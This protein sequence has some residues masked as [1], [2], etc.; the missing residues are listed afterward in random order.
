MQDF[1]KLNQLNL[2][3]SE[4][5]ASSQISL[6]PHYALLQNDLK[7]LSVRYNMLCAM[8]ESKPYYFKTD[9]DGRFVLKDE[10]I[11]PLVFEIFTLQNHFYDFL[12]YK[13]GV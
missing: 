2:I 1:D 7:A 9:E 8:I 5:I 12:H 4:S 10:Q 6:S 11:S 13:V 3:L